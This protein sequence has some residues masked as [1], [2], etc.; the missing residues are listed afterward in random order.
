MIKG[1]IYKIRNWL[2]GQS[3]VGSA[4]KVSDRWAVHR[5]RL[6]RGDHHS[7][8]LQRAWDRDGE[9]DF[10]FLIIETVQA[11][12]KKSLKMRLQ[13]REQHWINKLNAFGCG[14]N[15]SPNAETSLGI[16]RSKETR[17]R[18]VIAKT[19]KS[20]G[21]H[22]EETKEKIRRAHLGKPKGPMCDEH[23]AAIGRALKGRKMPP[24]F[25]ERV[26][27]WMK[28]RKKA[29]FS[30]AHRENLS[31]AHR[32]RRHSPETCRKISQIVTLAHKQRRERRERT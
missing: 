2:T 8:R 10:E 17:A 21:R 30:H 11:R 18:I 9:N 31:K 4:V 15:M 22:T 26:S 19:G 29:P 3:Y 16:K 12:N 7:I 27:K 5:S 14:Y 23:K 32:G 1:T 13:K 25:G 28:G 20:W 6:H 24:G